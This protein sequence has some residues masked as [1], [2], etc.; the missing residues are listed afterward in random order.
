MQLNAATDP[1]IMVTDASGQTSEAS[2]AAVLADAGQWSGLAGEPPVAAA[3]LRLL[4]AVVLDATGGPRDDAEWERWWNEGLPVHSISAY[5]DRHRERMH[6]HSTSSPFLQDAGTPERV[7]VKS[8]AEL[9]PHLPTGQNPVIYSDSTDLNGPNPARFT[10]AEALR[11][12]VAFHQFAR[13]GMWANAAGSG[14]AS[15]RAGILLDRLLAIPTG[16]TLAHTLILN[17]P[18]GTAVGRPPWRAD[19]P[20]HGRP[21]RDV[22]ELLTWQTRHVKLLPDADG[23][24]TRLLVAVDPG[25]DPA[26]P[27]DVIASLDLHITAVQAPKAAE[28][29]ALLGYEPNVATWRAATALGA[30]AS[31]ARMVHALAQ[32]AEVIG[33]IPV[34]IETVGLAVEAKSKYVSWMRETLPV[35]M[36]TTT[37]M[38]SAVLIA[39]TVADACGSALLTAHQDAGLVAA[40]P[41]REQRARV[42]QAAQR[43][44][45]PKVDR[46]SVDLS[47]ELERAADEDARAHLLDAWLRQ[48]AS[49]AHDALDSCTTSLP[50]APRYAAARARG[51]RII[52]GTVRDLAQECA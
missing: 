20:V 49:A 1:W 24:V 11:W 16:P 39:E 19:V 29:W 5:L 8:V 37:H 38:R 40:N 35:A 27:R 43:A 7:G 52:R 45:W 17:L 44:F 48:V 42:T 15:G 18:T 36:H 2:M 46:Y 14:P 22:I 3:V 9:A 6:L 10:Q 30:G 4:V 41:P 32:R 26:V 21:P 50:P 12:L 23:M 28:G 33:T 13:T 25:I 47:E 34:C 31:G 51:H